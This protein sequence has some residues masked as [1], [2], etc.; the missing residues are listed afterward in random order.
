MSPASHRDRSSDPDTRSGA[1][2]DQPARR[3]RR[4]RARARAT[5]P[6]RTRARTD[7]AHSAGMRPGCL[8]TSSTSVCHAASGSSASQRKGSATT[9]AYASR[10]CS[11]AVRV[12]IARWTRPP[13]VRGV[14][15]SATPSPATATRARGTSAMRAP[16]RRA[17]T[18]RSRPSSAPARAGSI[19]P[20]SRQLSLRI[21]MP[22]TS[23]PSTSSTASCWPWSSSPSASPTVRPSRVTLT[24]RETM[25]DRSSQRTSLGATKATEGDSS[26]APAR[27]LSASRSGAVSWASSQIASPS[28]RRAAIAVASANRVRAGAVMTD[29]AGAAAAISAMTGSSPQMTMVRA[30]T[31]RDCASTAA[32]VRRRWNAAGARPSGRTT[33]RAW[34]RPGMTSS[35]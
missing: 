1:S 17:R 25:V 7:A 30:S 29:S 16:A 3:A 23:A 11:S 35:A 14:A 10:R 24:P 21:R 33:R 6:I 2:C 8:R 28:T 4:M 9:L 34:T 27:R 13:L 22:R 20:I 26:R 31:G 18:P 19:P 15:R 12:A 5:A 32:S